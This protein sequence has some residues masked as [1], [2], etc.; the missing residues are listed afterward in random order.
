LFAEP[1]PVVIKGVLHVQGKIPSPAV[2]LPLLPAR[3]D[4][5]RAVMS[6]LAATA[7]C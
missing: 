1:N 7:R 3:D 6:L 5:V 4:T 2:R